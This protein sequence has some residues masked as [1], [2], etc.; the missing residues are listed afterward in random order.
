ME[1]SANQKYARKSV[2]HGLRVLSGVPLP[3]RRQLPRPQEPVARTRLPSRP[4][5]LQLLYSLLHFIVDVAMIRGRTEA[6]LR[7]EVLVLRRRRWDG[8]RRTEQAMMSATDVKHEE[9]FRDLLGEA[10][11]PCNHISMSNF[12]PLPVRRTWIETSHPKPC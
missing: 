5:L 2:V 12:S 7:T 1:K 4:M 6:E 11:R 9:D 8:R 10:G 3:W